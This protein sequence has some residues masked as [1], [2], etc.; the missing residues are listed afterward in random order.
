MG[1][2][3]LESGM[4]LSTLHAFR[5]VSVAINFSTCG[6]AQY[7]QRP[8][9]PKMQ[10]G[11]KSEEDQQAELYSRHCPQEIQVCL[12]THF[13][14]LRKMNAKHLLAT[15]FL[16]CLAALVHEMSPVCLR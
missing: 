12:Q 11:I 1:I 8:I 9:H 3:I 4:L 2:L 16:E 15:N 10:P 5:L 7:Q 6:K 13:A 14:L